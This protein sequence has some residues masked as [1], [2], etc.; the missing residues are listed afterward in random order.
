MSIKKMINSSNAPKPIGPYSQAVICND[1][2]FTSGQIAIN[3]KTNLLVSNDIEE[4]TN[5]VLK[6]LDVILEEAGS[7]ID[8]VVKTTIY[9]IDLNHFS[10]VN[11]IYEK[12][13]GKS[14]PARSTVEVN[15]LPKD[16]LIEIDCIASIT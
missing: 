9:L 4:Q 3:P 11:K 5:Q 13:F 10:K 8:S 14:K 1:F 15:R 16:V 12:F 7:S 2:I 6:N